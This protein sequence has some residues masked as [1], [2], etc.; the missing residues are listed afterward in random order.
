[1]SKMSSKSAELFGRTRQN[2]T[3][4]NTTPLT[5]QKANARYGNVTIRGSSNK[6]QNERSY[7]AQ[8]KSSQKLTGSYGRVTQNIDAQKPQI[9]LET[10]H[11]REIADARNPLWAPLVTS[12]F[13]GAKKE[14]HKDSALQ[15]HVE[16][17]NVGHG[18]VSR[19]REKAGELML[20]FNPLSTH[21]PE[22]DKHYGQ[23]DPATLVRTY[24]R[25]VPLSRAK[26]VP[27]SR[28]KSVPVSRAEKKAV[29]Q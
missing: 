25:S 2:F 1:M 16:A 6:R 17:A 20:S 21:S 15:E 26:S 7:S 9:I 23:V 27:V 10:T 5:L 13:K 12:T 19:V 18:M 24:E 4:I 14:W 29:Q 28:A 8:P 11:L 3:D 22:I